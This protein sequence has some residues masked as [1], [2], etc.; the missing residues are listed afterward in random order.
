M[1]SLTAPVI[2]SNT[3]PN[4]AINNKSSHLSP[5]RLNSNPT[6]AYRTAYNFNHNSNHKIDEYITRLIK[7]LLTAVGQ[8]SIH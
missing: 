2:T 8:H 3:V 7:C 5:L 1:A 6:P 4:N